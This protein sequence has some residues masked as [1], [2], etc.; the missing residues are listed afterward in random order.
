MTSAASGH[1]PITKRRFVLTAA[2]VS[3]HTAN[4]VIKDAG[5]LKAF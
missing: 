1:S 5:L 3:R 2:I 4:G